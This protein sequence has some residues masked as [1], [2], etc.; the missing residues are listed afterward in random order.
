MT[1]RVAEASDA[2]RVTETV[3]VAIEAKVERRERRR[4]RYGSD[5]DGG[6]DGARVVEATMV[7]TLVVMETEVAVRW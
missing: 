7:V 1:A 6:G 5:T 4:R 2:A 3:V